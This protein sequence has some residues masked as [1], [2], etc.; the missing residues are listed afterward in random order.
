M[1]ELAARYQR[2]TPARATLARGLTF[3]GIPVGVTACAAVGTLGF[4]NGGYFPVTWGWTALGLLAVVALAF[5]LSVSVELDVLD[6]LFLGGLIG[7]AGWIGLSLIWTQS[8]PRTVL[9]NERMVVYLAAGMAGVL[10]VRRTSVSTLVLGVW[11]GI[12]V[13]STYGLAG[14]LFP[15]RIGSYDPIAVYR[16]TYPVG[17][18]NAFGILAAMGALLALGLAARS[19]P[20]VRCGAAA[21]TV[22][23]VLTLYFTYSR[24]AWVAFF[25]GLAAA[26]AV[27]RRRLQLITVAFVLAPWPISAIWVASTSPA[28]T[29]RGSGLDVAVREGHGLAVI[30]LVLIVAAAI[31][32]LVFDWLEASVTV[33]DGLRRVYA[34]V[35]L[36]VLASCL[37]VVSGRYGLPPTMAKKVYHAFNGTNTADSSSD[38]NNRLFTLAG[39]GRQEQIHT[40]TQLIASHPVLGSGPGTYDEYWF[41][42]RRYNTVVHDA[43]NLYLETLGE[44]GPVG[45]VLLVL[46]LG[47]P[48]AA[49]PRARSVPLA[50]VVCGGYVAYLIHAA[51][52]WDWEMPT[53][54]LTGLFLGIAL[55]AAAR[56]ESEPRPLGRGLRLTALVGVTAL[57]GFALLGLLGNS[58]VSASSK[59]RSAGNYAKAETDA[60]RAMRYAPWSFQ[61]WRK[62][63]EAQFLAGNV[64]AARASFR[65]AVAKDP[66]DWTLW[67]EL[68]YASKGAQQ[69]RAYAEASRLNP[70]D[71]RLRPGQAGQR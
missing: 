15:D 38:L 33:P 47:A 19:G 65:K 3:A 36:F 53:V 60:R 7:L 16:L 20:V 69:K 27:D 67:Y 17:Y 51:I 11:L 31:A 52:D 57:F 1:A 18:W 44:M 9:E 5:A 66:N 40:A 32:I 58:A 49:L 71:D 62:L 28:L 24:G 34:G 70:L 48:L 22:V 21:S 23:L 64:A 59:A 13:V 46:L 12:T 6:W 14:R 41:Q 25:A 37:I 30:A 35:L 68:A 63:G 55:L 2:M 43:H 29:H 61:P 39:N 4:A 10:L 45:L 8:V 56:R 26:V 54:T 50:G 42:H